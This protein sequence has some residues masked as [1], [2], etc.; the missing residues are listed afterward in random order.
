MDS[1]THLKVSSAPTE[2]MVDSSPPLH[3]FVQ[4]TLAQGMPRQELRETLVNAG[5]PKAMV[6]AHL[7][8]SIAAL[9][10][11][12]KA[13]LRVQGVSKMFDDRRVLDNLNLELKEGEVFGITGQNGCGKTTLLHLIVGFL[14]PD[15]GDISIALPAGLQSV[16]RQPDATK[17]I[18]GYA[19][20][21]PSLYSD[22]TT[23]ENLMHFATLSGLN[24]RQAIARTAELI[25]L[26][27]L[28]SFSRVRTSELAGGMQKRLDIACALVHSP[29][30]LLLD[31]PMADLDAI[32]TT[33]VW[34]VIKTLRKQGTTVLIAAHYLAEFEDACDRIGILRNG[35]IAEVGTPDELRVIY[36]R[37]Q[38]VRI[39]FTS[40]N[41]DELARHLSK[42]AP[43]HVEKTARSGGRLIIQT[44]QPIATLEAA[45]QY[46]RQK[47]ETVV[48]VDMG[49]PTVRELL[50]GLLG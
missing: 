11:S 8:E 6:A 24:A 5:W 2:T 50:E 7:G 13:I 14:A 18:I 46:A 10:P 31:E 34:D 12:G 21:V 28:E 32:S 30:L 37:N 48:H 4:Q 49:R 39:E 17:R 29:Q 45:L 1:N 3:K 42:T 41:Y 23:E 43:L 35:R 40:K 33:K 44:A 9:P 26:V 38:E 22:L 47:K 27:G 25:K 36:S 16:R 20:Q 15:S 19:T